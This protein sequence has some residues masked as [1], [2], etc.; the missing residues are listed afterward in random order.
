M[1]EKTTKSQNIAY[2][3]TV[4]KYKVQILNYKYYF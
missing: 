2:N 1:L 4:F 3:M